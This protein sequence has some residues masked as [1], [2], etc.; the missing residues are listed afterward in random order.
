MSSNS[1]YLQRISIIIT[2]L[3]TCSNLLDIH[4]I[5]R[6]AWLAVSTPFTQESE[7]RSSIENWITN[8]GIIKFT[9]INFLTFKQRYFFTRNNLCLQKIMGYFM[10]KYG[11]ENEY[12]SLD[13]CQVENEICVQISFHPQESVLT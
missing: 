13:W 4:Q 9:S 5:Y 3:G 10:T 7:I 12:N 1:Y 2:P 11:I 8:V 6:P